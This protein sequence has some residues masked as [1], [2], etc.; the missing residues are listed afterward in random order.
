[1]GHRPPSESQSWAG[2]AFPTFLRY[3]SLNSSAKINF[4]GRTKFVTHSQV[5][6][7]E[8]KGS[9]SKAFK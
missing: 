7:T 8:L 9:I 2:Q 3:F 4:D 6:Q 5:G 1:M